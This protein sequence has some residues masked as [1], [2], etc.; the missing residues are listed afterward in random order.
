MPKPIRIFFPYV[1]GD[2][3]GGSHV[4]SLKLVAALDRDRFEP[5]I[6]LHREAGALGDYVASL[7]MKYQVISKPAIIAPRY[8]RTSADASLAG[9]LTRSVPAFTRMLRD[10][11]IDIV[12]TN[13]GRMHVSWALPARLSGARFVWYHRQGPDASGVNKI[14]PLLADKILSVS[15]FSRPSHPIRSVDGRFDVVRSPFDFSTEPPDAQACHAALCQELG[16]SKNALLLGYFGLLNRRKRPDH[17]VRAIAHIAAA[18]PD[19]PVHGLLFGEVEAAAA[20]LEDDC[21]RLALDLGVAENTHLMG[22][23][24]PVSRA[25]AGVDALL[26]T[27]LDEPFGRT[28]VEAMDLGTPVVATAHGGNL[29]A[30]R[31]GENGFLVDPYDATAFVAPLRQLGEKPDMRDRLTLAARD[32]VHQNMGLESHVARMSKIYQDIQS[33]RKRT[34]TDAA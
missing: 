33:Q 3:I 1:G 7:G 32:Y 22:H 21:Q 2:T 34:Y 9:Y 4:S 16:V 25:M 5:V 8:S 13:D 27:A 17:F 28:L 19:R 24:T 23:R 10:M 15:H 11:K 14:A 6:A 29:E 20:G 30:I 26:V 18:M 31:D 12:H